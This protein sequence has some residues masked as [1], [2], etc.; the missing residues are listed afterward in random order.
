M[1]KLT[2]RIKKSNTIQVEFWRIKNVNIFLRKKE[3]KRLNTMTIRGGVLGASKAFARLKVCANL[4]VLH[5][6]EH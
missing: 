3:Y 4:K 1:T 5:P 6:S 2:C